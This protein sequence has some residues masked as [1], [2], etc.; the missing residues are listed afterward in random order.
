MRAQDFRP[1]DPARRPVTDS[2]PQYQAVESNA[3]IVGILGFSTRAGA[4][5][6]QDGQAVIGTTIDLA[7]LWSPRVRLRPSA[8]VG[9][10]RPE[11]SLGANVE[12]LFRF[13]PE[14]APAIPYLGTGVGYYDDGAVEHVWPTVVLGFELPYR[15]GMR[16]L[17]EYHALDGLRR[18]RFLVGMAASTGAR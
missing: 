15:G 10:G 8:E 16:W 7:Q 14:T 3:V 11:K 1:P 5:V 13:Q 12:I 2:S 4:Q 18:S 6:T 17:I 9:F